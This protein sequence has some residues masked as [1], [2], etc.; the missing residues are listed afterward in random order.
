MNSIR[1]A[2]LADRR[3]Q[4]GAIGLFGAL[5]LGLAVLFTALVV[6]AGRLWFLNRQLQTVA[7]LAAI[8]AGQH[9]ACTVDVA[10]VR[11]AAQATALRNGY[12]GNLG[13]AP[14]AVELGTTTTGAGGVRSF[15][16]GGNPTAVRVAVTHTVN[17]SIV[18]GGW[19]GRQ[20]TLR[21]EAVAAA[22]PPVAAFRLGSTTVGVA[23]Q[24]LLNGLLTAILGRPVALD[25]L[26]YQGLASAQLSLY[27]L[28]K[29]S[30]DVGTVDE[31][32]SAD[33][34]LAEVLQL[35]ADALD[36]SAVAS[37]EAKVAGH[38]LAGLAVSNLGLHLG[39][40]VNVAAPAQEA[41]ANVGLNVLELVTAAVMVASGDEAVRLDL[42][43]PGV[44]EI[45]LGIV[46]PP[47]LAVGPPGCTVART[48][49]V[50]LSL[51]LDL[52]IA[53]L[54]LHVEV[55]Q[56]E[57]SLEDIRR[58][59]GATGV[60]ILTTPGIARISLGSSDDPEA[61]AKILGEVLGLGLTLK[62]ESDGQQLDFSVAHPVAEHLPQSEGVTS[63]LG[64]SL[65]NALTGADLRIKVLGSDLLGNIL[66][67]I[68]EPVLYLLGQI[69]GAVGDLLLD[70]LLK[71]LGLN[72]GSATVQLDDVQLRGT[73]QLLL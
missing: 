25:V 13:A 21:A 17:A 73:R 55:A 72:I 46:E 56:S 49:Q 35:V 10:T 9:I 53:D 71:L 47:Q 18:A 45:Y 58:E 3:R 57:A 41:A 63:S 48:A 11:A 22:D 39:D 1:A 30:A 66:A 19:L 52:G 69:L 26:S 62:I 23:E 64:D 44:A 60:D 24:G 7:D 8:E 14:N 43:I 68:L 38:T 32:L 12:T 65:R 40:I 34:S 4:R 6:D 61:M 5:T 67:G 37:V 15:V 59:D 2:S 16:P 28:L 42:G 20:T 54:G 31:L 50:Q 70:P 36:N 51:K 29:V 27:D 33:V